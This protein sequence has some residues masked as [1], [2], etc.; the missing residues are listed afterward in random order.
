MYFKK[1]QQLIENMNDLFRTVLSNGPSHW[2]ERI[3]FAKNLFE[4]IV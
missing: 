2:T 4:K 3:V 1:Q